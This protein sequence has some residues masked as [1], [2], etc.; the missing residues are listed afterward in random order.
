VIQIREGGNGLE[1]ISHV[2]WLHFGMLVRLRKG[3]G[4]LGSN[5][6]SSISLMQRIHTFPSNTQIIIESVVKQPHHSFEASFSELGALMMGYGA[7][8]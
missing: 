3:M 5:F 7:I 1:S 2:R 8:S 6:G 4:P